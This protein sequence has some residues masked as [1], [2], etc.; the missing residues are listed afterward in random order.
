MKSGVVGRTSVLD[1]V[2]NTNENELRLFYQLISEKLD[3]KEHGL[4]TQE[5]IL[6]IGLKAD[7]Y[8]EL[9]IVANRAGTTVGVKAPKYLAG[10]LRAESERRIDQK[11]GGKSHFALP[12]GTPPKKRNPF[13]YEE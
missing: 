8:R 2:V 13:D 9:S 10:F 7:L 1:L 6:A 11:P 3:L 5:W 12:G 4:T